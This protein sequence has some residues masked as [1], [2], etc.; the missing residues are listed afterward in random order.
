MRMIETP[1]S[2]RPSRMADWIGA[3]PRSAGSSDAWTFRVPSRGR[4]M[5]SLGRMCP[6]A[7]T[8]ETSGCSA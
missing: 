7:T 5:T 8:T 4:S 1:V 6:Y 2:V 3:A